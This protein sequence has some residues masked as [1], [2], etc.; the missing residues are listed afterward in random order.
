MDTKGENKELFDLEEEVPSPTETERLHNREKW[1]AENSGFTFF[2]RRGIV[3]EVV[4]ILEVCG[5]RYLTASDHSF[6]IIPK[7]ALLRLLE[8]NIVYNTAAEKDHEK[9][10]MY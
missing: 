3:K 9:L 5:G 10:A 1:I 7:S 8:Y 6:E 2:A 4:K